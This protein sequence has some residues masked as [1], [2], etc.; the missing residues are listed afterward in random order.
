MVTLLITALAIFAI[1]GI[2]LY[3]WQKSAPNNSE[4]VLPPPPNARGLFA[5]DTLATQESEQSAIAELQQNELLINRIRKGERA[6]LA[7]V[8]QTGSA[9]LYDRALNELV[10]QA[11][12]D[13]KLLALISYVTQNEFPVNEKLV[14]AAMTSWQRSPDRGATAKALH[15]AALSDSADAY[16]IAVESVLKFWHEGKLA[17]ISAPEL[18]ALFDG[19]FWVLSSRSRSSGAGFVLKRTLASARRELEAATGAD[20]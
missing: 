12:T 7:D 18:R 13:A 10:Q 1:I 16:R 15:L 8:H 14:Q 3:F 11:D 9:D 2:G 19:E 20:Q 5:D 6:A 17:D 4:Y